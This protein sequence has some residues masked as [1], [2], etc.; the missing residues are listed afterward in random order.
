[1]CASVRLS[2][3]RLV[4]P[5]EL[6][7]KGAMPKRRKAS[8]PRGAHDVVGV[9]SLEHPPKVDEARLRRALFGV[10]REWFHA[11]GQDPDPKFMVHRP[12]VDPR[13]ARDA[14][15]SVI[16]PRPLTT[17]FVA[18]PKPVVAPL[19]ASVTSRDEAVVQPNL[20]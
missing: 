13:V 3:K 6:A 18:E 2:G 15:P 1:V 11:Q 16:D 8:G 7:P 17:S 5:Y 19:D 4:T 20:V 12:E 9:E 14:N 10:R